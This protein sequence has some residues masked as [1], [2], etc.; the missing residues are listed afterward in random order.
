[1]KKYCIP[2]LLLLAACGNEPTKNATALTS[3]T[4]AA[5]TVAPATVASP[6]VNGQKETCW[7]GMLDGKVPIFLHYSQHNNDIFA[8]EIIYLNTKNKQPIRVLGSKDEEGYMRLLEFEP[9]GNISGIIT[10][11]LVNNQWEEGAWF[12][13]K[14][15]K[16]LKMVLQ[17]KDTVVTG[18]A[19]DAKPAEIYGE[20]IYE[21]SAEGPQGNVTIS[22]VDEERIAFSISAVTGAPARNIADVGTDTVALDGTSFTYIVP[23][24]DACGFKVSFYKNCVKVDYTNGY[25]EGQF[26]HNATVEGIFIKTK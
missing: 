13:P 14:T 24:S 2:A 19:M 25:C 22:K 9:S 8:G 21:Y 7:T 20:Y 12:S 17:P 3:D 6:A 16:D 5:T 23:G 10:G 4:A 26:G 18:M 15:R 11:K 1:M